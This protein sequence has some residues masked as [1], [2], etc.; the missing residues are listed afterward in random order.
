[1]HDFKRSLKIGKSWEK[2]LDLLLVSKGYEV[3]KVDMD[4]ERRGID[5][6]TLN[7]RGEHN[8]V[9]YKVDFWAKHTGN[10][11]L[12]TAIISPLGNQKGWT[13]RTESDI[14]LYW[15][16]PGNNPLCYELDSTV[17]VI[18]TRHLQEAMYTY[19]A[20]FDTK[21]IPNKGFHG[22]GILVP[23]ERVMKDAGLGKITMKKEL[24]PQWKQH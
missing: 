7:P 1:V 9:E 15:L 10:M 16:H 11:F 14:I 4:M 8:W 5:R 3:S 12:E 2:Y 21:V 19:E 23:V 13:W 6:A 18:H 24:M 22:E 20:E 17:C